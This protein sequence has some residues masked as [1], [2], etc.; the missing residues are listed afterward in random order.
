MTKRIL[1][2]AALALAALGATAP[3]QAI[4][5]YW[6]ISGA[7]TAAG[8]SL[9]GSFGFDDATGQITSWN[10]RI[11]SGNGFLPYTYLPGNSVANY[12]TLG[13][14]PE[15]YRH[16]FAAPTGSAPGDR[17]LALVVATPLDGTTASVPLLTLS[18]NGGYF[19]SE[20]GGEFGCRGVASGALTLVP[21][22]P[23]VGLVDVIEFYHSGLDHYFIT[24][25]AAE[26]HVL[27]VGTIPGWTRTG[28]AFQAL[29]VGSSAGPTQNPVCRYFGVPVP[30]IS[31]HFYSASAVECFQVHQNFGTVWQLESENVFQIDLP[32]TATGACP[33][34]TIPVY[35]LFNNRADA[36]HRYTTSTV[37]RAQMEA[38]GWVREGY[39]PNA[40][41]LC[42]IAP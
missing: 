12:G 29:A 8:D 35:R 28:Y 2:V 3:A 37:V 39:G 38:A 30:G 5:R 9:V 26:V 16:V 24:G 36:N 10:I 20:C 40:V 31:S 41:I 6:S 42:A 1:G 11:G 22:P 33:G 13:M 34:T 23:P 15:Q 19:S 25:D 7:Q 32:D 27:D 17:Y 21:F 4:T 14:P 18:S